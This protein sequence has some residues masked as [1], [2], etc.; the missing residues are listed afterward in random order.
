MSTRLSL[1]RQQLLHVRG[2]AQ[3]VPQR[4]RAPDPLL[5]PGAQF[6]CKSFGLSLGLRSNFDTF[7]SVGHLKLKTYLVFQVDLQAKCFSF[8]LQP[9]SWST[10]A[11]A[12]RE[13]HSRTTSPSSSCPT[14]GPSSRVRNSVFGDARE[15]DLIPFTG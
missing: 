9:S 7:L 3:P 4:G 2:C 8:E 5:R 15:H 11:T 6:N 14:A 13:R 1:Q 12:A 10:R